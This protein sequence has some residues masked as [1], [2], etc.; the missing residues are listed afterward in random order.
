MQRRGSFSCS[1]TNEPTKRSVGEHLR[2]VGFHVVACDARDGVVQA[3]FYAQQLGA[4]DVVFL[5]EFVLISARRFFQA[6]F[7]CQVRLE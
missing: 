6:T 2:A 7:K 5:C 4:A 3:Y 1:F